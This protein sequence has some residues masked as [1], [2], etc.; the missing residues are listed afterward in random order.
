MIETK[1][2]LKPVIIFYSDPQRGGGSGSSYLRERRLVQEKLIS[3]S[4]LEKS[5]K[6]NR[7]YWIQA[8]TIIGLITVISR[9]V[10]RLF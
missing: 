10:E 9:T 7:S 4:A 2:G 3:I 1:Q 5:L 8:S 6:F